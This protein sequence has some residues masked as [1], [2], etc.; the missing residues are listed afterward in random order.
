M[1][2]NQ[3]CVI[4]IP[5]NPTAPD[6][7]RGIWCDFCG[8]HDFAAS[9]L[10][11][12]CFHWWWCPPLRLPIAC[13]AGPLR[14]AI[15]CG[16]APHPLPLLIACGGAS[17]SL[18]IACGGGPLPLR[19]ACGGPLPLLIAC[20]GPPPFPCLLLEG[21]A[22]VPCLLL[23]VVPPFL[24]YCL[25]WWPLSLI[26]AH[27]ITSKIHTLNSIG[28]MATVTKCAPSVPLKKT[29]LYIEEDRNGPRAVC[30]CF[31]ILCVFYENQT[32][33][34]TIP[35]NSNAPDTG[36]L[37]SAIA[38]SQKKTNTYNDVDRGGSIIVCQCFRIL[39]GFY[40]R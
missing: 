28:T 18:L 37:S 5:R 33:V 27:T 39:C 12:A 38:D 35:Q 3:T 26:V 13:G 29:N 32:I 20:D 21:A 8:Q 34:S 2:E 19:I 10:P 36:G 4:I 16:G 30:Q 25:W 23:V 7:R 24:A 1:Y 11:L 17:L 15:A 31:K 14:L 9:L 6:Y 22:P 40:E